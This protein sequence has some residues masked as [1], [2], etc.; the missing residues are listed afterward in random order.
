[1]LLQDYAFYFYRILAAGMLTPLGLLAIILLLAAI[2]AC[3]YFRRGRTNIQAFSAWV[4]LVAGMA[5]LVTA[6]YSA[7]Y[8][9]DEQPESLAF[10]TLPKGEPT[11][12]SAWSKWIKSGYG[13]NNNCPK[14]CYRGLVL[15]KQMRMGGF[16]P[17]PEYRRELQCWARE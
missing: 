1:M 2:S 16:P 9:F 5:C 17:W 3:I 11:C 10:D 14:G 15:R 13:L 7:V 12:D 4:L 6:F 8:E